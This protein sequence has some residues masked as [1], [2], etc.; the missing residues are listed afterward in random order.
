MSHG[1]FRV[2]SIFRVM[3][4]LVLVGVVVVLSYFYLPSLALTSGIVDDYG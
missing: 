3:D 2:L 1:P 4:V